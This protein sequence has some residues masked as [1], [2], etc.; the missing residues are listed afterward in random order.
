MSMKQKKKNVW[1]LA[2]APLR[3]DIF[4]FS[5]A[6]KQFLNKGKTERECIA[7]AV[8]KLQNAGFVALEEKK[9]LIPGDRVYTVNRN[10]NLL[11]AVVGNAPMTAGFSLVAAHVD[12]PRLDLKPQPIYE[13][14]EL[15]FFKTHYYGGIKKYQWTSIPLS[16]HGVVCKTDG[17]VVSVAIGE[18]EDDPVFT[19][20]DL[21]PHL[22][23]EQYEKKLGQAITGEALNLL[24]GSIPKD[25]EEE[26]AKV[27][28][29][30]L[31]LIFEKYGITEEDFLSAELE[32]VPAFSAQDLGFD[33]SMIGAYGHDDRICAFSALQ[34]LLDMENIPQKTSVCLWVDKEEIGSAGNTG[35]RS[36][37]FENTIAQLCLLT[38][39]T[40]YSDMMLRSALRN[41]KCL[42]A[43]VGAAVD[44]GYAEVNDNKNAAYLNHGV[45]LMK[46]TGSGGKSGASDANPEFLAEVRAIF[47]RQNVC[48]QSGELGKVDAGGGGTIAH[49]LAAMDMDVVDCGTPLLSMHAPFEVASKAD[50]YM[51]YRAYYAFYQA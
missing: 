46:Y 24:I 13:D 34:A 44:P 8:E 51:T 31:D 7:Y 10:K 33:R 15:C 43:D 40:P 20:T 25:D 28:R 23:R 29:A 45:L 47:D 19:V 35:M 27:K 49:F 1:E 41:G 37:F 6:Y 39:E 30:V 9:H 16:L 42:S 48:W 18:A 26:T 21:L 38:E 2:D 50:L 36:R 4:S 12:S 17:S 22:A 14:Q 5:K 11:A 32:A 3:E